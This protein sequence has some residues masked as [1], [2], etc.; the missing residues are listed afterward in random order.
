MSP[1][2][3]INSL[4]ILGCPNLPL[5]LQRL[6]LGTIY[7]C[8]RYVYRQYT[9]YNISCTIYYIHVL[10]VLSCLHSSRLQTNS[11]FLYIK[12]RNLLF[13]WSF[14]WDFD[15]FLLSFSWLLIPKV[16][17]WGLKCQ[18]PLLDSFCWIFYFLFVCHS[19]NL[20]LFLKWGKQ[21]PDSRDNAQSLPKILEEN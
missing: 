14:L 4:I 17:G 13:E 11:F 12:A 10:W 19:R 1:F 3:T 20:E 5:N 8:L 2:F 21:L 9:V 7:I 16:F 6:T 15:K 18:N